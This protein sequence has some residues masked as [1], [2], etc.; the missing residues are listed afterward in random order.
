MTPSQ[1]HDIAHLAEKLRDGEILADEHARLE[2]ILGSDAEARGYP[3]P[4]IPGTREYLGPRYTRDPCTRVPGKSG[5]G[6]RRR[7]PKPNGA[8]A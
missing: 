1:R 3:G 6:Q 7:P 5:V 4:G 2:Q 8:S